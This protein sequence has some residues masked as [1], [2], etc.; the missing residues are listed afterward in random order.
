MCRRFVGTGG[1]A[2]DNAAT[3][4]EWRRI[5]VSKGVSG[6]QV[7]DARI[8][9]AMHVHQIANLLTLNVQDFRRYD[10]IVVIAPQSLI[11][12]GLGG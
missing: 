5:V 4:Q 7:H 1:R 6:V 2:P 10:T 12:S 8:V 11:E 3:H 9:A